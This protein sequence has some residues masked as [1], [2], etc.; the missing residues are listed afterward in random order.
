AQQ[1]ARCETTRR[2]AQLTAAE[3]AAGER[4]AL[5]RA[6]ADSVES[7]VKAAALRA[8]IQAPAG[9]VLLEIQDRA[10]G[11]AQIHLYESNVRESFVRDAL[12]RHAA[13]LA[14]LSP[15][16][17][18]L[19]FRLEAVPMPSGDAVVVECQPRLTNPDRLS[20][21]LQRFVQE[22][23]GGIPGNTRLRMLVTREGEVVYAEVLPRS[24]RPALDRMLTRTA[25]GLR[26]RPATLQGVPIDVW[27]E[28]P[29][30]VHVQ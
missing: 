16:E 21:D 12:A 15:A 25:R 18:T 4:A 14:T 17:N 3:T 29:V 27:V 13:L 28:Q 24:S 8:G 10:T 11:R 20:R 19:H 7:D 6:V 1:G 30:A 26:F 23:G 5:R 9:L 2:P 22:E